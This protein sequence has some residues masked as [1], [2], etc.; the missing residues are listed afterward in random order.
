M[1][2]LISVSGAQSTAARFSSLSVPQPSSC[3]R[4]GNR[5]E[6]SQLRRVLERVAAQ[7]FWFAEGKCN[8]RKGDS[9]IMQTLLLQAPAVKCRQVIGK[10][11]KTL[12]KHGSDLLKIT[13]NFIQIREARH[14]QAGQGE[15]NRMEQ[16]HPKQHSHWIFLGS[17]TEH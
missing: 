7:G 9:V 4:L 5:H 8:N 14:K 17:L 6:P 1:L 10:S 2:E 3:S 13:Q 16:L 12:P 11:A 15:G